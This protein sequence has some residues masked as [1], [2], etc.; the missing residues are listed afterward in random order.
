MSALVIAR[1]ELAAKRFVFITAAMLAII[2]FVLPG[3][4]A[5]RNRSILVTI[6]AIG[7]IGFTLGLAIMLGVSTIGRDLAD[8]RLSFYFARPVA[9]PA[10]WFGKLA[11]AVIM[12]GCS[13]AV[14]LLPALLFGAREW[15]ASWN[16]DVAPLAGS[17]IVASLTLFLVSHAASTMVRSRSAWVLLDL[18][19]ACGFGAAA[20]LLARPLL[21][22]LAQQLTIYLGV[23]MLVLVLIALVG[24]GA[25]QLERGRTDRRQNHIELSRFLWTSLGVVLLLA[26]GFVAWVVSATPADLVGEIRGTQADAGPWLLIA[27]ATRN[28]ADYLSAFF[29]NDIDG[30]YIRLHPVGRYSSAVKFSRDGRNAAWLERAAFA[31]DRLELFTR[32]L[33]TKAPSID[34]GIST[35]LKLEGFALSDDSSR[36]ALFEDGMLRVVDLGTGHTLGSARIGNVSGHF[37]SFL[38]P[39][40]GVVR[41]YETVFDREGKDARLRILEFDPAHRALTV[42]A[43]VHQPG[44]W[45]STRLTSDGKTMLIR[46][47]GEAGSVTLADPRTATPI[48][49]IPAHVERA[50]LLDDGRV[51]YIEG[52]ML[53]VFGRDPSVARS[54]DLGPFKEFRTFGGMPAPGKLIV[55]IGPQLGGKGGRGWTSMLVDVDRGVIERREAGLRPKLN[56]YW[57]SLTSS[58]PRQPAVDPT[59]PLLFEDERGVIIRWNPLTGEKK[60]MIP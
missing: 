34:T 35:S 39:S 20:Y 23:S 8:K 38:F 47:S 3:T 36:I 54:I 9:A 33:E 5:F 41:V 44:R 14:I 15:R 7:A 13:F 16:V 12:L 45:I 10:I 2:P 24:A 30:S 37:H 43:D 48:V 6:G 55:A 60:T 22:A 28:R 51:A 40:P 56:E 17:V 19:L 21:N 27:G 50:T 52:A 53:H 11:A 18:G 59:R 46:P 4:G 26:G 42:T 29:F 58:D 25:W 57:G 32:R 1:R 49:T 31:N